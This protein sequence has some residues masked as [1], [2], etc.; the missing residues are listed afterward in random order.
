MLETLTRLYE[1]NQTILGLMAGISVLMFVGSL[2]SLPWLLSIIPS[3]YFKDPEPYRMHHTFKHPLVRVVIISG[4]NILGWML[5][6]TGIAML[7]LPGQGLL[8]LVMGLLLV[9]FPGNPHLPPFA[10]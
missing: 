8:T 7:V 1:N 10:G 2:L 6:L 9:D 5:V 3:D 4:K